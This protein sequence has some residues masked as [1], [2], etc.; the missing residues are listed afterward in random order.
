[1]GQGVCVCHPCVMST[2]KYVCIDNI[3]PIQGS[4]VIIFPSYWMSE[5]GFLC[6]HFIG[7]LLDWVWNSRAAVSPYWRR[8]CFMTEVG[9]LVGVVGGC[10]FLFLRV[11]TRFFLFSSPWLIYLFPL[12]SV[13]CSLL[14]F[15]SSDFPSKAGNSWL[16]ILPVII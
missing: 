7:R 1:M 11:L 2:Y 9:W 15:P 3:S 12:G 6:L 4:R 10:S 8:Y 14:T 16:F 5:H 13:L